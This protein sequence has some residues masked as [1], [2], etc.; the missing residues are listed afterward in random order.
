[1]KNE[2]RVKTKIRQL[3]P[4]SCFD[5]KQVQGTVYI[6]YTDGPPIYRINNLLNGLPVE[7]TRDISQEARDRFLQKNPVCDGIN[8]QRFALNRLR[9][10]FL[11][12]K[13]IEK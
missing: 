1:M 13:E 2:T 12:L 11:P 9:D 6:R 3:Y 5:I 4:L 7:I 10:A 8:A